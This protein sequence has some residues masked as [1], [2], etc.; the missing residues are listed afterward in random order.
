MHSVNTLKFLCSLW[1]KNCHLI[2]YK[3]VVV[4]ILIYN[5]EAWSGFII[6][7]INILRTSQLKFLRPILEVPKGTPIAVL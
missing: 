1:N 7:K 6:K 4:P 3:S 5:C 2:L